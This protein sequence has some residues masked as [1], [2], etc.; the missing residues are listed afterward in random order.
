MPKYV[1]SLLVKPELKTLLSVLRYRLPRFRD[2]GQN[3]RIATFLG[4][5][6]ID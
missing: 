5:K 4:H 3:Q 1:F 6:S 2:K